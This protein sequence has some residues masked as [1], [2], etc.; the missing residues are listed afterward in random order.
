MDV[1]SLNSVQTNQSQSVQSSAAQ[2]G[3]SSA[4]TEAQRADVSAQRVVSVSEKAALEE[5]AA[6]AEE[7]KFE[8]IKNAAAKYVDG[9]NSFFK[10]VRFTVNDSLLG[11]TE[12]RFTDISTGEIE[13][14]KDIE[15]VTSVSGNVVSGNV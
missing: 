9:A 12:I 14:K 6:R 7:K 4:Q 1:S 8:T 2:T 13:V 15:L 3:V 11:A 10:D 5:N